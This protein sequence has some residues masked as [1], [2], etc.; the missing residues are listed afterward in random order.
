MMHEDITKSKQT[1]RKLRESEERFRSLVETTSDWIWEVDVNSFYT[2]V[3]PKIKDILGYEPEEIIGKTPF[4]LMPAD[5]IER[6]SKKF[7][8]AIVSKK[9]ITRLENT[10]LHKDGRL[11]VLETSGVP[12]FNENGDL[13]GYRGIDRDI[14][15]RK[16]AEEKLKESE[17]MFRNLFNNTPY[18]IWLVDLKGVILDCNEPMNKFLS[19][20]KPS[21]LIGKPFRDVLQMF[22]REGDPRFENIEQVLKKRFVVLLKEGYLKPIEFEVSRGDGKT[23]WITLESSFVNAGKNR[24]IQTFI[25]DITERKLA[26]IELDGLRK[27]LEVR[28]KER[29]IKLESS[30]IKYRK[31]YSRADCYKGLFTHDIS[32]MFHTIGNS[33]ELCEMLL[34]DGIKNNDMIEYFE[35]IEQQIKRGKKL[36]NNIRNL[37]EIEGS[38]MPLEPTE[39][40]QKLKS[41]IQYVKVNFQKKEIIVSFEPEPNKISVFANDLLLDVFENILTNSVL[42]NK[43]STVEIEINISRIKENGK[44]Y[45]KLEFKDNGVGINDTR[46][47]PIFQKNDKK[48]IG[49]KGM[50]LGL[51][52]VAKLL[53]LCEGK[54]WVEDR[55]KGDY[56]QGSNFIIQIPEA[57]N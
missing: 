24:L 7:K 25:T 37:S 53:E 19:I 3:S 30:E 1:E 27:E 41:A 50:G 9:S 56:T 36:I 20:F 55:I 2:Y 13:L 40:F 22:Y 34:K 49:S 4:D 10:N 45:V 39:I 17:E 6:V 14:T 35:V 42:Y 57:V 15:D 43:N 28:I 21:D 44:T 23:F 33:I 46:K 16:Q 18:A 26:E 51:S 29:T 32:N 12:I 47:K 11:I 48:T 38:E 52:L 54:I 5:E 8:A 31:A